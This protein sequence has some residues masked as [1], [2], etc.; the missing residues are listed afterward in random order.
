M[1]FVKGWGI[2]IFMCVYVVISVYFVHGCAGGVFFFFA[3]EN[4]MYT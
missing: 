4:V 1:F 2:C 3:G